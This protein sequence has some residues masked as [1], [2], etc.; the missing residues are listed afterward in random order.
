M[1]DLPG[2]TRHPQHPL[3]FYCV[4]GE[5]FDAWRNAAAGAG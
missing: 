5:D 1:N 3:P 2:L 4:R